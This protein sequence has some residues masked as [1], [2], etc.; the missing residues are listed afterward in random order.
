MEE[1]NEFMCFLINQPSPDI[2]TKMSQSSVGKAELEYN[3]RSLTV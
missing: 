1:T 3:E 2:H